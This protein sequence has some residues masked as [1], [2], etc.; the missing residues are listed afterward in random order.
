MK[1]FCLFITLIYVYSLRDRLY[2]ASYIGDVKLVEALLLED[3]DVLTSQA[4]IKIN[5]IDAMNRTA[6]LMC[7][8]DP[9]TNNITQLD[10]DCT[11]IAKFLVNYGTNI[12]HVDPLGWNAI[13]M[14]A[15]RGFEQFCGIR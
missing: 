2:D 8:F 6:L 15:V 13:S 14:G 10:L 11:N 1:Y 5:G 4:P 12:S 7:G 3:P 9:Q